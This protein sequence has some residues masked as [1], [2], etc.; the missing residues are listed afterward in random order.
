MSR[1]SAAPPALVRFTYYYHR[2]NELNLKNPLLFSKFSVPAG[3]VNLLSILW[4]TSFPL[5]QL[6]HNSHNTYT[7]LGVCYDMSHVPAN[8]NHYCGIKTVTMALLKTMHLSTRRVHDTNIMY[9]HLQC[10]LIF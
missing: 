5:D 3:V 2:T 9:N 6:H 10:A 4:S 7:T 1:S 8:D